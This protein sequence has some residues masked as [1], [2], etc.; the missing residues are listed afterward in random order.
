MRRIIL[1]VL[2]MLLVVFIMPTYGG[3]PAPVPEQVEIVNAPENPVPVAMAESPD[4][5]HKVFRIESGSATEAMENFQTEINTYASEGWEFVTFSYQEANWPG[6]V[7][8]I[9]V[10]IMKKPI[11]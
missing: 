5:E 7:Y 2:S 3:K 1:V 4:F 9:Y 11:Q 8:Y 6:P 10:G